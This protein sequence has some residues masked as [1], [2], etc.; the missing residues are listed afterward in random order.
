MRLNAMKLSWAIRRACIYMSGV[1]IKRIVDFSYWLTDK[2]V[3]I[4]RLVMGSSVT[5]STL[6]TEAEAT[7]AILHC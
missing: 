4:S 1:P 7:S 6:M 3:R 2:A 5:T